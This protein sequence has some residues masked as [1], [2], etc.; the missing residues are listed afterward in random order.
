MTMQYELV[1]LHAV[2]LKSRANSAKL[3]EEYSSV[4]REKRE[5][6]AKLKQ[7]CLFLQ[8]DAP[9]SPET[10]STTTHASGDGVEVAVLE[11]RSAVG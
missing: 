4:M 7:L 11:V 1:K 5:S 6:D 10:T 8:T 9:L 3:Q 2:L